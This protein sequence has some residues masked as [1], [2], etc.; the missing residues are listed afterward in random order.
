MGSSVWFSA[1]ARQFYVRI[2]FRSL[3]VRH[4]RTTYYS[5]SSRISFRTAFQGP[6]ILLNFAF[7][8]IFFFFFCLMYRYFDYFILL[9][10]RAQSCYGKSQVQLQAIV[11][12]VQ[13]LG[14][15]T[16]NCDPSLLSIYIPIGTCIALYVYAETSREIRGKFSA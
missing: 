16:V 7:R 6:D 9:S 4:F 14:W 2:T 8:Y 12:R 10:L 3:L 15:K 1:K 5:N 13:R 11:N